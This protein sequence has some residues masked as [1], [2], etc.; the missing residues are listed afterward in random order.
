V[1]AYI[2][3]SAAAQ[4]PNGGVLWLPRRADCRWKIALTLTEKGE[5]T[6]Q[7]CV[8]ACSRHL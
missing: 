4:R 5:Q 8:I 7:S 2:K 1:E 3:V 6:A